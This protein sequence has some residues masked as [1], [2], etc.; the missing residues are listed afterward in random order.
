MIELSI[1]G[2]IL[3]G[4]GA[5]AIQFFAP[6]LGLVDIPNHR[7]SHT[8]P[9]PKGGG[10]G[11]FAIFLVAC[12]GTGQPLF[13]S[14]SAASI[15]LLGLYSDRREISP[16]IRLLLQF[17]CAAL[18]V[19]SLYNTLPAGIMAITLLPLFLL[20]IVGTANFYNFMDGIN[21]IAAI[22]GVISF[23]MMAYYSHSTAP[24]A[25]SWAMPAAISCSCLGFLPFNFPKA[26]IFMG[27][28]GSVLL[29][30]IF[31]F[32]VLVLSSNLLDFLCYASLLFP[33]YIDE[34]S[35]MVIRLKNGERLTQAHRKH[36][37]Q[38][39]ANEA[40]LAHWKVSLLYGLLQIIVGISVFA[41]K[42]FGITAVLF[43]LLLVSV[44]FILVSL[45][46]RQQNHNA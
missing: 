12:A 21:G 35:T 24:D 46:V 23:G 31:A 1:A 28:V 3:G 33:F 27:D 37:Y 10:I 18:A 39:L 42:P 32:F 38:I 11:I 13:F 20:F 4:A 25:V 30:F 14:F 9:T 16:K 5:A 15:A 45:F 43:F 6:R 40:A 36:L 44:S 17:S 22:T 34:L 8:T 19:I 26:R 41:L 7:S 29:G 2:F